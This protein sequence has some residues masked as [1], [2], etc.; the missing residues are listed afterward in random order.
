MQDARPS[1]GGSVPRGGLASIFR[2][3]IGLDPG[4]LVLA[5]LAEALQL[6]ATAA[7][8]RLLIVRLAA[9]LLAETA[10]LTELTK[11]TDGFLDRLPRTNP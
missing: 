3:R 4:P 5:G 10:A 9:H 7:L 1:R 8:A 6:L 2:R 11:P